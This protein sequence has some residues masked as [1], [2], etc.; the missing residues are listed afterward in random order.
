MTHYPPEYDRRPPPPNYRGG[1]DVSLKSV[2][3]PILL[4]VVGGVALVGITYAAAT[5]FSAIQYSIDTMRAELGNKIENVAGGLADRITRVEQDADQRAR[6]V[7]TRTDHELWCSRTEQAYIKTGWRC[8]DTP[9]PFRDDHNRT[10]A[11]VV[12]GWRTQV[13]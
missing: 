12:K 10:V 3:V 11:P 13:K 7:W 4:V 2:S 8:V 9:R 5:Q 1:T 6:D